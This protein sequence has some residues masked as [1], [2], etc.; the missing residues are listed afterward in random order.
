MKIF[1][2]FFV[3]LFLGSCQEK[4]TP[5]LRVEELSGQ[6]FGSTY[7]IK[8]LGELKPQVFATDLEIFFREF[9][10]EFSTYQ[11]DSVISA[12]NQAP[13]GKKLKVSPRFIEMLGIIKRLHHATDGAFDPTIRPVIKAWGFYE[14]KPRRPSLEQLTKAKQQMGMKHVQW[15]EQQ[16]VAWKTLDELSLDLNAFAPGWAADLIGAEL[17]RRNVTNFMVEI[18][19][20]ILVKGK[21]GDA[22][23]IIGIEKPSEQLSHELQLA[24]KI[25][26]LSLSTSGDYRQF[27]LESGERRSHIID[28]RTALPVNHQ[29]SSV[30]TVASSA[31]EADAWGTALMILGEEGMELAER[32]KIF[33]LFIKA[34]KA[35]NFQSILS[36]GMQT[37]LKAN[38]L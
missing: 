36:P 5:S 30:T 34:K 17:Q 38:Q 21:K 15:D 10:Q 2:F 24:V 32:N 28:P 8:Y 14:G 11:K 35:G 18:G 23:W 31:V 7:S 3:I 13:A 22:P 1:L 29:I 27:F 16:Q 37:Y 9:N 25:T 33:S 12:F 6:V 4:T 26:D 19:G 20:E